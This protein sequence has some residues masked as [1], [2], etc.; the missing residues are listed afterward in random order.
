MTEGSDM[1]G[2]QAVW[3]AVRVR[4]RRATWSWNNDL[5][6]VLAVCLI[7]GLQ[8][9]TVMQYA[10]GAETYGMVAGEGMQHSE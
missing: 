6:A 8:I 9:L 10:G 2:Q 5:L 3:P 1:D 4:Q 7:F